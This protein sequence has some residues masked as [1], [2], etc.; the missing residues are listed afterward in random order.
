MKKVSF[1]LFV[2]LL[3]SLSII[4]LNEPNIKV[5]AQSGPEMTVPNLAVRTTISDLITPISMAFLS[6]NDFFVLEKN[7]GQVK[8]V[9]DGAAGHSFRPGS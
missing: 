2:V 5:E 9:V 3:L 6:A 8:R 1:V 7:T 4:S